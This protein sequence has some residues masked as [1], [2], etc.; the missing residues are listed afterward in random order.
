MKLN[1]GSLGSTSPECIGNFFKIDKISKETASIKDKEGRKW[2]KRLV[3][4]NF[5]LRN[6]IYQ[7]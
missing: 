2:E 4:I 5:N 6:K 1:E 3:K 7:I